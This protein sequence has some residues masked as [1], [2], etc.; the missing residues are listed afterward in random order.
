MKAEYLPII[1]LSLA[2]FGA[3][4]LAEPPK[5]QTPA[6]VIYLADNL[7]EQDNLGW[8]IDTL[9][10]NFIE[11]LQAYSCKPQGGDVQFSFNTD[12]DQIQ[13]VEYSEFC[14]A[15]RP[16]D[17][18]TFALVICDSNAIDQQFT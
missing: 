15:H 12:R 1:A 3:P 6:P 18:S 11:R 4:A 8:C 10:R 9:G 16:N 17:E 2:I 13:S 5:V 14:I 7:D